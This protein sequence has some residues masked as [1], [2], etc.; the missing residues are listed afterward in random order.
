MSLF[1]EVETEAAHCQGCRDNMYIRGSEKSYSSVENPQCLESR[2]R[3][4]HLGLAIYSKLNTV[5]TC[6]NYRPL[7]NTNCFHSS[8]AVQLFLTNLRM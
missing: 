1:P 5:M 8:T 2:L 6:E 4:D 3:Q 7:L